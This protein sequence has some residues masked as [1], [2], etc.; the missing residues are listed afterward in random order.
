[1]SHQIIGVNE[2]PPLK[3]WIPLSFQHVFAM[4]GAT[5]LVP[6]LTGLSPSAALFAAGSG[7]LLYILITGAQVPAFLGSSFAFITP[8]ITITAAF[9]GAYALGGAVVAGLFY[10]VVAGI[11]KLT[12]TSWLDRVMPPVVIGSVIIVI[13]LNLAPTAMGMAMNDSAGNYSLVHFSIAGFT[14]AVAIVANIF[15]KGFFNVIP[16]LLG[17]VAGYLFTLVMGAFFPAYHLINFDVVAKAA[18]FSLPTFQMPKFNAMASLTFIIVSLATICE[19]LGDIMVTS[20]VVGADFYKKP[21]LHRTLL[22]DGLATAWAAFWGGPPNTTYG[23]NIG[24]M[25]IT[26]VYSVWVIGGA[27]VVAVLL[28][29]V[30][31]VG[32]VIQTIP[33][34]VMGGISMLL[35]GIIASSG[36]R[37]IAES[38]V[39]FKCKRNLT[40]TSV[41]LVIGIGGGKL[42]FPIGQGLQFQLAGVALATVVG[43]LLNLI[44]PKTLDSKV[45]ED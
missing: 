9:G 34:P 42:A 25:A 28:S 8:I 7:T 41:I 11:I 37:T 24:V 18:W 23:E 12:G 20:R 3:K 19:H 6:M 26:R 39:D 35:F 31:K 16:I 27:A 30:T 33:T 10:A 1:M 22:G 13:G 40:I 38:G 29:L 14:L 43:I 2:R 17:L 15:F 45:Q 32:A 21:G 5:V 44:L 4:F 36:L